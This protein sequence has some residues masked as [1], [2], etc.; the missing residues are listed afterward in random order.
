MK[1]ALH[2]DRESITLRDAQCLAILNNLASRKQRSAINPL[3]LNPS[4]ISD[5]RTMKKSKS[6]NGSLKYHVGRRPIIFKVASSAKKMTKTMF[7]L[8][9]FVLVLC[10]IMVAC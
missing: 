2:I 8:F 1:R 9:K 3:E 5:M 6:L 4:S 10:D 7:E